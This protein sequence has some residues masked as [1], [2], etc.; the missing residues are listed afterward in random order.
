MSDTLPLPPG[1]MLQRDEETYAA[2][3]TPPSGVLSADDLEKMA[4]V[5]RKYN[6]PGVKITSGQ[7]IGFYGLT[8]EN[9]HEVCG[10]MPFR[11]GGHY[12]QACPGTD[13]CMFAHKN[14]IELAKMIEDRF[15]FEACPA[16]IKFG[17]SACNFN[18]GESYVRDFGFIGS[19]KGWTMIVGG[20]SGRKSRLGDV[21]A[22]GLTSQEALEMTKRF[23][24][25]YSENAE[26][27]QRTAHFIEKIGIDAVKDALG[28]KSII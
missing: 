28:L 22:K 3:I 19:P 10:E 1:V 20:N 27:K 15:G 9:V 21:I 17:I 6:I 8:R 23:L 11:T 2:R 13:W 18:C 7:R 5:V 16:K 24:A 26:P 25:F 4:A 12:V 14:S